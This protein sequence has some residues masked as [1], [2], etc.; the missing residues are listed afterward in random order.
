MLPVT[1]GELNVPVSRSAVRMLFVCARGDA[2]SVLAAVERVFWGVFIAPVV[3]FT[4]IPLVVREA[5]IVPVLR[6][7]DAG[8]VLV[9]CRSAGVFVLPGRP[10][11]VSSNSMS[12]FFF[13]CLFNLSFIRNQW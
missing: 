12:L 5:G 1:R 4:L 11:K 13:C 7:V 9:A 3:R 6:S 2:L 8:A 10:N